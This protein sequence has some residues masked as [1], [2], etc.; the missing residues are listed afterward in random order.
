MKKLLILGTGAYASALAVS[1]SNNFEK[2]VM[3]GI[4]SNEI[5]DINKNKSNEK[6]FEGKIFSNNIFATDSLEFEDKDEFETI[7]IAIPSKAI[8]SL[9]PKLVTKMTKPVFWVNASKGLIASEP[10]HEDYLYSIIPENLSKGI[11][12]IIGG[13]FAIELVQKKPSKLTITSKRDSYNKDLAISFM[14]EN[15]LIEWSEHF[16]LI[17]YFAIFKN[18]FAIFQGILSGMGFEKNTQTFLLMESL[19]ETVNIFNDSS[20]EKNWSIDD[21]FLSATLGDFILTGTSE[22][23]RNYSFGKLVGSNSD[24]ENYKNKT[25]EGLESLNHILD[26][27]QDL[28]KYFILNFL[29]K[30]IIEKNN[31]EI[32]FKNLLTSLK[33]KTLF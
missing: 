24:I 12:R 13:T 4:D 31:P 26:L 20:E 6:Y 19:K 17:N 1:L 28:D 5:N 18:I 23:S 14:T 15:L 16:A 7:L 2:I 21:L 9:V 29:K 22:K 10:I 11:Y 8:N 30:V 3:Y 33:N 27:I 25:V 32:E